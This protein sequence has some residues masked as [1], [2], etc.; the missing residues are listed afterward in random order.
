MVRP[1]RVADASEIARL[2][3]DVF[4]RDQGIPRPPWS[5]S[6]VRAAAATGD[7]F[8]AEQHQRVIGAVALVEHGA[9]LAS[10]THA[11][12]SQVLW[13]A[14]EQSSRRS[15]AAAALLARCAACARD[16]GDAAIVLWTRP[17]MRAAQSLYRQLGYVRAPDRDRVLGGGRQLTYRLALGPGST[18]P[19]SDTVEALILDLLEWMGPN[20]RPYAD[21]LE[22]W[23]T[24]CP[25]L[26]VWEDAN[27]R[28][29]IERHHEP[30]RGALVS[31][32][33]T[34]AEHLRQYRQRQ[35]R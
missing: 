21:V 28:G 5:E 11:G 1:A 22:A 33:A 15:G 35:P 13:L 24:S 32:S 9:G 34:G 7:V 29:F 2:W 18:P 6:D 12:E 26:P 16:R 27:D 23:R 3:T 4:V 8:V 20:P 30:G 31:V 19:V 17:P 10:V 14:V 25:R